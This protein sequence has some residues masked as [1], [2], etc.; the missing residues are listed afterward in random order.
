M[1]L[2]HAQGFLFLFG[3]L[4]SPFYNCSL[5]VYYWFE[6]RFT[7][8]RKSLGMIEAY[9]HF[10]SC[11]D[12][13]YHHFG[14]GWDQPWCHNVLCTLLFTWCNNR[15]GIECERGVHDDGV[16]LTVQLIVNLLIVPLII[17]G[18]MTL[19]YRHVAAQ[20]QRNQQCRGPQHTLATKPRALAIS[21]AW[22]LTSICL[23]ISLIIRIV[24]EDPK[25][26][27]PFWLAL[28]HFILYSLQGFSALLS[29]FTQG[30]RNIGFVT[31][32]KER[33]R[34][35]D[36]C[37]RFETRSYREGWIWDRGQ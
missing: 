13:E 2:C 22:F 14:T 18:S 8:W 9:L 24:S 7:K 25:V 4:A 26:P 17:I 5:C 10:S 16:Y 36:L 28:A 3:Q 1:G 33:L 23:I 31:N 12:M 35:W 11:L 29:I 19:I 21:M 27:I 32:E 20:D 34:K 15:D 30:W 37:W 6:L